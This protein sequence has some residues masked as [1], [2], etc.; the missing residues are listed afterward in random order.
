MRQCL[1]TNNIN[2]LNYSVWAKTKKIASLD[3]S[4][5]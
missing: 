1:K 3:A 5:I 4:T 2:N